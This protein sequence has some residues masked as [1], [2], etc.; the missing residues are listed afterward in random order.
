MHWL[1]DLLLNFL[2]WFPWENIDKR[3]S[4]VGESRIDKQ[5]R[6]ITWTVLL[7]IGLGI[8]LIIYASQF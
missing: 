2:S 8:T 7:L 4:V 3:R 6:W 5:T 1:F